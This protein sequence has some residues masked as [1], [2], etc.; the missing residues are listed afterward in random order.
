VSK[1]G[2]CKPEIDIILMAKVERIIELLE[3]RINRGDYAL[4]SF[5]PEVRLAEELDVSRMTARKAILNLVEGGLLQRD[6]SGRMVVSREKTA[7]RP[8]HIGF[9]LPSLGSS[10]VR[11]RRPAEIAVNAYGGHVRFVTFYHWDDPVL[12]EAMESF[13]GLF[14]VPP[15]EQIPTALLKKL[16]QARARLIILDADYT[17]YGLRSVDL[18]PPTSIHGL[19]DHLTDLGHHRI[20]VFNTQPVDSIIK[21]RLEQWRLWLATQGLTGQ[22][23]NEPE[24]SYGEPLERAYAVA[25]ERLESGIGFGGSAVLCLTMPAA[26]G[27]TR[28]MYEQGQVA[29]RDLSVCCANDEGFARYMCPSLTSVLKA[30]AEP[31]LRVCVEWMAGG[32]WLGP[33]LM[34]PSNLEVFIGETT[35]PAPIS[36]TSP[37]ILLQNNIP[38]NL[39][40]GTP[41][42][43]KG[44]K[45]SSNG[46]SSVTV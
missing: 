25:K 34:R 28:A 11:W 1:F 44:Q 21:Q 19:L 22:L 6:V 41:K 46:S 13:D 8:L 42:V 10:A 23:V 16:R 7:P 30:A 5:P 4:T 15:A 45:T 40:V 26:I 36:E 35:G 38:A 9:L 43:L 2:S 39:T 14:L 20:S 18:V 31:Y 12:L 24:E 3:A 37:S 27:L 32:T 33:L 17:A 29:G